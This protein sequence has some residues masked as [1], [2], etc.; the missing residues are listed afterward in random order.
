MTT[1]QPRK[2]SAFRHRAATGVILT[3]LAMVLSATV[4]DPAFADVTS[5]MQNAEFL[6]ACLDSNDNGNVY[7]LTCNGGPWQNWRF[8]P[9]G[10]E[11]E[12]M[13][14]N[15]KTNRCLDSNSDGR[16]YT[17]WCNDGDFQKW[18][19]SKGEY[20]CCHNDHHI[21][22]D[23]ATGRAVQIDMDE[24]TVSAVKGAAFNQWH[25]PGLGF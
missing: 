11:H 18:V 4:A 16:V 22:T 24:K 23:K 5:S 3:G 12:Y 9:T 21:L 7:G 1:D 17:L 8:A 20:M 25:I 13:I 2:T 14:I 10:G 19:N 15:T 6:K